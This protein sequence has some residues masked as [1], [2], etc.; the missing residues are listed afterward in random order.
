MFSFP[1]E[2]NKILQ[3]I[4]ETGNKTHHITLVAPITTPIVV[5]FYAR[6]EPLTCL[7][8]FKLQYSSVRPGLAVALSHLPPHQV[9]PRAFVAPSST[10]PSSPPKL[11]T[12]CLHLS[13][14]PSEGNIPCVFSSLISVLT[15]SPHILFREAS[16][17]SWS[18]V[19]SDFKECSGDFTS[20]KDPWSGPGSSLKA[21]CQLKLFSERRTPVWCAETNSGFGPSF[22]Q[23]DLSFFGTG[24]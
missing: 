14:S 15:F 10:G 2:N 22:Y 17:G 18:Q 7:T 11:S 21:V 6:Q 19:Q 8:W 9:C 4:W 1:C 16:P 12:G 3:N 5:P 23:S 13:L 24:D 20:C